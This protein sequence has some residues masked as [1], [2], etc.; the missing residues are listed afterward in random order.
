LGSG[1]VPTLRVF[2]FLGATTGFLGL[3]NPPR[4]EIGTLPL[5]GLGPL[6]LAGWTGPLRWA[7]LSTSE[8]R[9][10]F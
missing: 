7:T 8:K 6:P 10:L 5:L 9:G 2:C 1:F 3:A 4:S